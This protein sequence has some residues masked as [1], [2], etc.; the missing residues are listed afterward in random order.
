MMNVGM[1][2]R[3]KFKQAAWLSAIGEAA[4]KCRADKGLPPLQV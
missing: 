2:K 4:D 3:L 1:F